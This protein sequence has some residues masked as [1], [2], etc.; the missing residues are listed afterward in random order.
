MLNVENAV[1][2]GVADRP[3]EGE[4]E[5]ELRGFVESR[6]NFLS[7]V[8]ED[9]LAPHLANVLFMSSTTFLFGISSWITNS[10]KPLSSTRIF[11]L[12]SAL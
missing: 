6:V 1:L 9:K 10:S 2:C 8:L 12:I 11:Y 3:F 7:E 5:E 4:S